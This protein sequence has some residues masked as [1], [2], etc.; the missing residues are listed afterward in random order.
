MERYRQHAV[1][2]ADDPLGYAAA[3]IGQRN[4]HL[5]AWRQQHIAD[6]LGIVGSMLQ[7]LEIPSSAGMVTQALIDALN[8]CALHLRSLQL[9][10][11][12]SRRQRRR[13]SAT[14][15][16]SYSYSQS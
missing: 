15:I 1:A 5:G 4:V 9:R 6:Q 2:G 13:Y 11:R 7:P 3:G 16:A 14:V 12:L 8:F 10:A